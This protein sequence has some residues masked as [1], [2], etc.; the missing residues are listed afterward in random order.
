[1]TS[2]CHLIEG[3]HTNDQRHCKNCHSAHCFLVAADIC[4]H[5]EITS[6]WLCS[7][8]HNKHIACAAEASFVVA[9]FLCLIR[10]C[11]AS[12]AKRSG[13]VAQLLEQ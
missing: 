13:G 3:P 10:Y 2:A 7:T 4:Y 1:M 12:E 8:G 5:S 9:M 6:V 11:R